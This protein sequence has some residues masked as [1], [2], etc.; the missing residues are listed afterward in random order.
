VEAYAVW[1]GVPRYWELA[2][3]YSSTEAAFTALGLDR[4]GVLHEEPGRLLMEEMRSTTQASS[5][6]SLIG[7]GCHRLAEMAG[8]LGKPAGSLTRPL[9]NLIELG[10]V[11]RETPWGE[12]GRGGKRT[13]YVVADPYLRFHYRFIVP[14]L[15]LLESGHVDAVKAEIAR[16]MAGHVAGIWEELARESVPF[17]GLQRKEWGAASR[18]WGEGIDGRRMEIDLV[19]ESMD[20]KAVL[21]GEVKWT[22]DAVNADAMMTSLM[23]RA[24]RL[25]GLEGRMPIGAL[26]LRTRPK[27]LSQAC[28]VCPDDVLRVMK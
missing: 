5:L 15:S 10:Y 27:G 3:P 21:V 12:G 20:R 13:I 26:W 16:A 2:M 28:V 19:A 18:W 7:G 17:L 25:P 4:D 22:K 14:N 9:S 11:R 24:R 8:R 23:E 1:G 6:L